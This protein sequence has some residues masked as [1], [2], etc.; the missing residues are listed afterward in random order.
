VGLKNLTLIKGF[1]NV[2][3][4]LKINSKESLTVWKIIE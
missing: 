2:V 3:P 1:P 4:T